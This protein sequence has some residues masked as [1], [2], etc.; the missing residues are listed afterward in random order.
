MQLR[1]YT[2]LL[3]SILGIRGKME[4]QYQKF[5]LTLDFEAPIKFTTDN[6]IQKGRDRASHPFVLLQDKATVLNHFVSNIQF[7]I[8][9]L[10]KAAES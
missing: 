9:L 2:L 6:D 4:L 10:G 3:S 8:I 5:F 1:F 7:T